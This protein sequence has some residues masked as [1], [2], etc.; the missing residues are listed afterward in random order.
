[1]ETLKKQLFD[2]MMSY[3][4]FSPVKVPNITNTIKVKYQLDV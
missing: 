3:F 2:V 1:M 4:S